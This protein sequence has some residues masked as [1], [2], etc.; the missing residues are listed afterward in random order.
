[1]RMIWGS[2]WV[3]KM[4]DKDSKLR[5]NSYSKMVNLTTLFIATII[6]SINIEKEPTLFQNKNPQ[7]QWDFNNSKIFKHAILVLDSKII[8]LVETIVRITKEEQMVDSHPLIMP[9]DQEQPHTKI[10]TV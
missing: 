2:F 9:S 7:M 3:S 4:K 6:M 5:I 1:M 10:L 8:V